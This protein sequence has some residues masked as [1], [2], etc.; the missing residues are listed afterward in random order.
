MK[1][2]DQHNSTLHLALIILRPPTPFWSVQVMSGALLAFMGLKSRQSQ[3]DKLFHKFK[4]IPKKRKGLKFNGKRG[5][6]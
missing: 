4:G 5:R 1:T 6:R 3:K 2:K